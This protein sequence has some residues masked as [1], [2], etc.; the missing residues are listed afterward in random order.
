MFFR[1]DSRS[2]EDFLFFLKRCRQESSLSPTLLQEDFTL[3]LCRKKSFFCEKSAFHPSKDVLPSF[4]SLLLLSLFEWLILRF[5][6]FGV[7]FPPPFPLAVERKGR[8]GEV[9]NLILALSERCRGKRERRRG[10]WKE[11]GEW[12]GQRR[13][14][15]SHTQAFSFLPSFLRK[16]LGGA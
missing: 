14:L 15:H 1:K 12:I 6:L 16:V 8:R 13:R 2:K 9:L 10:F 4:S 5:L 11:E 7:A 3:L